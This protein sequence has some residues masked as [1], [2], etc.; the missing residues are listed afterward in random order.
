M[1]KCLITL[2]LI[3]MGVSNLGVAAQGEF[4]RGEVDPIIHKI[5]HGGIGAASGFVL[6]GKDGAISG[7]SAAVIAETLGDLMRPTMEEAFAKIAADHPHEQDFHNHVGAYIRHQK[8]L[9]LLTSVALTTALGGDVDMA[10]YA[11]DN[12]LSYNWIQGALLAATAGYTVYEAYDI[13]KT[14]EAQGAEA[15]AKQLGLVVVETAAGA[16]VGTVV[17]KVAGVVYPTAAAALAAYKVAN[18][19][20][21]KAYDVIAN[22]AHKGSA[23]IEAVVQKMAGKGGWNATKETVKTPTK[24]G[25]KTAVKESGKKGVKNPLKKTDSFFQD[26][27]YSKLT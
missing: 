10:T 2:C 21:A 24:D 22:V 13:Y 7:A 26:T 9:I 11:A 1:F 19:G 16:A 12:A 4:V 8:D 14:Y 25:A 15:A 6:H 17:F 18:P 27:K 23:A 20:F 5:L 3:F